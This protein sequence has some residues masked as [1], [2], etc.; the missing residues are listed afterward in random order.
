MDTFTLIT[1]FVIFLTVIVY[2][3]YKYIIDLASILLNLI[4]IAGIFGIITS[5]FLH[6]IYVGLSNILFSNTPFTEQLVNVDTI[7]TSV[8][9][10]PSELQNNLL[11]LIGIENKEN[12]ASNNQS[13]DLKGQFLSMGAYVLKAFIFIISVL[14]TTFSIYFR[15]SFGGIKSCNNLTNKIKILEEKIKNL[16]KPHTQN[17]I[18]ITNHQ[19]NNTE[20]PTSDVDKQINELEELLKT[21]PQI[22]ENSFLN[23]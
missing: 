6:P 18:P 4:F 17:N 11:E 19:T 5:L 12:T 8:K 23:K 13:F 3:F 1:I 2:I 9:N 20:K 15:Y 22:P 21:H 14:L 10:T 7:I 16:E